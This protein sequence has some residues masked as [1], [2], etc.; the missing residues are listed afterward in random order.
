MC[1]RV[2]RVCFARIYRLALKS[3]SLKIRVTSAIDRSVAVPASCI[4]VA[5][6]GIRSAEID[7][8]IDF[9]RFFDSVDDDLLHFGE[10]VFDVVMFGNVTFELIGVKIE[11]LARNW[12]NRKPTFKIA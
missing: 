4:R 10:L 8:V 5:F 7:K 6:E 1:L 12:V 3:I 9:E 2:T 11:R